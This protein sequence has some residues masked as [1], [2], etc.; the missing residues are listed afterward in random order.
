LISATTRKKGKEEAP[1]TRRAPSSFVLG[2]P[3]PFGGWAYSGAARGAR[4][5]DPIGGKSMGGRIASHIAAATG[6]EDGPRGATAGF[7]WGI[8]ETHRRKARAAS[9]AGALDGRCEGRGLL[10]VQGEKERVRLRPASFAPILA[11][12][13]TERRRRRL[14]RGG[15]FTLSRS[16]K[17]R[18]G[19]ANAGRDRGR[20]MTPR[21]SD[22]NG[23]TGVFHAMGARAKKKN[24]P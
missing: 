22:G 5:G 12:S 24:R 3:W 23:R 14:G 21:A 18:V 9:R 6:A 4:R 1:P 11:G 15:I 13:R 2:G 20:S 10:F 16:P 8:R 19:A 7:P 17:R